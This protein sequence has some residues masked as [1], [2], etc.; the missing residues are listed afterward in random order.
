MKLHRLLDPFSPTDLKP[1]DPAPAA[2]TP[3]PVDPMQER[4]ERMAQQQEQQSQTLGQVVEALKSM[5]PKPPEAAPEPTSDPKTE[6]WTDP[7]KAADRKLAPVMQ[8]LAETGSY[9][10]REQMLHK[11]PQDFKLWMS[12]IDQLMQQLHP[13]FRANPQSWEMAIMQVR[14]RHTREIASNP[15]MV[16]AFSEPA[17]PSSPAAPQ[18]PEDGLSAAEKIAANKWGVPADKY[19]T[20]KKAMVLNP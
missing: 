5:Q 18:K 13:S 20:Q 9:L 17:S 19:A 4:L 8:S 12:E 14:G 2:P 11:Y 6:W 7:E 1:G 10:V 3:T 16:N 15:D